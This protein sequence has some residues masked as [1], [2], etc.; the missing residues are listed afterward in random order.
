M[1]EASPDLREEISHA[2]S[3]FEQF[4]ESDE[5]FQSTSQAAL[6]VEERS[7]FS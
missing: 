2:M 5:K 4:L 1:L 6:Q 7:D 3:R